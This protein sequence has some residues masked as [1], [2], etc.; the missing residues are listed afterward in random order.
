M[1]GGAGAAGTGAGLTGGAILITSA[2]LGAG[3]AV[4]ARKAISSSLE[5]LRQ[6]R[7]H[8]SRAVSKAVKIIVVIFNLNMLCIL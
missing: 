3:P 7:L 2:A 1:V 8:K 5:D 6:E 4:S